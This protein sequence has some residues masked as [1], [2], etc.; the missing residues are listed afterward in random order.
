MQ[1]HRYLVGLLFAGL[2]LSGYTADIGVTGWDYSLPNSI[3]NAGEYYPSTLESELP[4]T[5]TVSIS[6][7]NDTDTWEVRASTNITGISIDVRCR[8]GT[9]SDCDYKALTSSK[10]KIFSGT[11]NHASIPLDF[12]IKNFDV[13]DGNSTIKIE[14]DYEVVVTP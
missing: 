12:M 5:A 14:I 13:T 4:T 10:R 2:S 9:V 7:L 6:G 8:P 3:T 1:L 11:G